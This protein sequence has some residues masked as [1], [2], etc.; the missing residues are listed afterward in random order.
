MRLNIGSGGKFH[1]THVVDADSG[2]DLS[3][4][5]T[6]MEIYFVDGMLMVDLQVIPEE[7]EVVVEVGDVARELL[8]MADEEEEEEEE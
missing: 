2:E 1:N 4:I 8:D 5:I 3:Q 7:L 6:D